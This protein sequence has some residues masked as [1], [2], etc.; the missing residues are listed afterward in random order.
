M[1]RIASACIRV[2]L[3]DSLASGSFEARRR[4]SAETAMPISRVRASG[5][6]AELRIT[7]MI[8]SM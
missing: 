6:L 2:R 3:V 8:S 7:R 5:G 4:I 1:A